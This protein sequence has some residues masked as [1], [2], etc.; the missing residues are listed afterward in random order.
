MKEKSK[1]AENNFIEDIWF[2][3]FPYWP[4]FALLVLI[5]STIAI[6]YSTKLNPT[7]NVSATIVINDDEAH[8]NNAASFRDLD[9][10]SIKNIVDNEVLVLQSRVL[11][12][13]VVNNLHLYASIYDHKGL[14]QKSAYANIPFL[15]EA[16]APEMLSKAANIPLEFDNASNKVRV[17]DKILP[18][19]AWMNFPFGTIRIV[20]KTNKVSV[21]Q[22]NRKFYFSLNKPTIVAAD[23]V[24]SLEVSTI[25]KLSTGIALLIK[26]DDPKKG[27]DILNELLKVYLLASV[28]N[29]NLL[30]SNTLTFIE[31]RLR[32]VESDLDSIERK[33][34]QFR[35]SQGVI[36]L[37][38]QGR[39]YL[40]SVADND[41]RIGEINTQLA[42][43]NQVEQYLN[44]QGRERGVVPT[45]LGIDDPV[46]AQL[47]QRLNELE[48]QSTNRRTK[49]GDNNPIVTAVENEIRKI[50]PDIRNI[51]NNQKS[52]LLAS[53]QSLSSTLNRLNSNIKNIPQQERELLEISRQQNVKR[54]LYSFLLQRREEAALSTAANIADNRVVDWADADVATSS[55][56]KIII[57]V[58]S[59]VLAIALGVAYVLIKEALSSKVLFRKEIEKLTTFPVVAELTYKAHRT[60]LVVSKENTPIESEQFNQLI[61]AL[62]LF[63]NPEEKK[64]I[65]V[66]SGISNEGKTF[67]SHNLAASLAFLGK[68]VVLLDLNLQHPELSSKFNSTDEG[69]IPDLVF[70]KVQLQDIIK[71]TEI[72]HLDFVPAG[73]KTV[74]SMELL[75]KEE[76]LTMMVHLEQQYDYIVMDAPPVEL[77]S[78]VYLLAQLSNIKLFI[79]R[80]GKTP[81]KMLRRLDDIALQKQLSNL[82]II[83]NGIK[84][85]GFAK[86]YYG[87]GFGFGKHFKYKNK[88]Y[89]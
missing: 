53:R 23:L 28:E 24:K 36:D 42:V 51:V 55:P 60:Q 4:L 79:I 35:S 72:A 62:N 88:N 46:L 81:V 3:F 54:E 33:I 7:Y 1:S 27:E 2:W 87:L 64:K 45:T 8:L 5:F 20:K 11:M 57:V 19:G 73:S 63:E 66:T 32:N 59:I 15:I 13:R 43:L 70:K 74:N 37:S 83:F 14:S 6:I 47:L 61:T 41:R 89:A 39:I 34:Q 18:I 16:K 56:L 49:T 78:D 65:L 84:G 52:R 69:G 10:Y 86:K 77:T 80:H 26:T 68:R 40:E 21:N 58:I 25:S 67:T 38:Q 76:F 22:K 82:H 71:K 12:N 85:R 44:T 29:E 50:R 48:L 9:V 17:N 31:E 30:A 75:L